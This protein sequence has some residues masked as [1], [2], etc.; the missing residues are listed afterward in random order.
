MPARCAT[1]SRFSP[2]VRR[3]CREPRR[4]H[5][6]VSAF[7]ANVENLRTGGWLPCGAPE[8]GIGR[9]Q[10]PTSSPTTVRT[11]LSRSLSTRDFEHEG[12]HSIQLR[13]SA[14]RG[15]CTSSDDRYRRGLVEVRAT[16]VPY[17]AEVFSGAR[18]YPLEPPVV[19]GVGGIGRVVRV[20]PDATKLRPGDLVWCD[21]TVR[22]R[23]DALTPDITLQGWSSRGEGGAELARYLHDGPF[24]ELM[25]VPTE[26]AVPDRR[27]KQPIPR[28]G[29]HWCTPFPMVG[30]CRRTC[31]R[32][33]G[34]DQR[35]DRQFRQRRG[36]R[37]ARHGCRA[38]WWPRAATGPCSTCSR[39]SAH[40]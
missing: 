11:V 29:P 5:R 36:S 20:G 22:A 40:G 13:D 37:R 34:A 28:A 12:S 9:D 19:P 26:N 32:R 33:D 15:R 7:G 4:P 8:G 18:R 2:G 10:Y 30:C 23:D 38:A 27:A 1:S 24:A 17:A 3:R 31:G 21:S 16:C 25:R 14:E 35:G 39:G 6:A